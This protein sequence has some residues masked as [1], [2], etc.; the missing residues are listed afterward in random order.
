MRRVDFV[1]YHLSVRAINE[2]TDPKEEYDE[3]FT[4]EDEKTLSNAWDSDEGLSALPEL[5]ESE[6]S[7]AEEAGISDGEDEEC[8]EDGEEKEWNDIPPRNW[9]YPENLKA[10]EWDF[11]ENYKSYMMAFDPE[12]EQFLEREI[13]RQLNELCTYKIYLR[14]WDHKAYNW[15]EEERI[16]NEASENA[17]KALRRQKQEGKE[18]SAADKILIY[19]R[20]IYKSKTGDFFRKAAR[21]AKL[22]E[23]MPTDAEGDDISD[24]RAEFGTPFEDP[25][26]GTK[27]T[28]KEIA[29]MRKIL[30]MYFQDLMDYSEEPSRALAVM[31]ARVLYQLEPHGDPN[32]IVRAT[33]AMMRRKGWSTD[34]ESKDYMFHW[35]RAQDEVRNQPAGAS[36]A[37]AWAR[38]ENMDLELL[39]DD[40]EASMQR[41]FDESLAW[42]ESMRGMLKEVSAKFAPARWGELIY[43]KC[44]TK[45]DVQDWSRSVHEST[46]KKTAKRMSMDAECCKDAGNLMKKTHPLME[47]FIKRTNKAQNKGR[48]GESR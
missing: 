13:I 9:S 19:Y 23:Q 20:K 6:A 12:I 17:L 16:A 14:I 35:H 30:R 47:E 29:L 15:R 46:L 7:R 32:G 1:D 18:L 25:F 28:P 22:F 44:F 8:T 43:T 38:M 48:K 27:R 33:E 34:P 45:A 21:E 41:N 2:D 5:L 31:Y 39:E 24:H 42:G 10:L 37:W 4:E 36:P 11:V 26:L 40:S 3:Y